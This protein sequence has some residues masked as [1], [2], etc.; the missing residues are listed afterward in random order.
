[1]SE[2]LTP[3]DEYFE[4]IGN[5]IGNPNIFKSNH[6]RY[7]AISVMIGLVHLRGRYS[8]Q[9]SCNWQSY[10]PHPLL[11]RIQIAVTLNSLIAEDN[12]LPSKIFC[13]DSE[14]TLVENLSESGQRQ[15]GAPSILINTARNDEVVGGIKKIGDNTLYVSGST[16]SY[17]LNEYNLRK[18]FI[19]E[20]PRLEE[21]ELPSRLSIREMMSHINDGEW[22]EYS[23]IDKRTK[24]AP[25][26]GRA[27]LFMIP[28]GIRVQLVDVVA[29]TEGGI[30]RRLEAI[31][32]EIID[33]KDQY[34]L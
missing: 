28:T 24:L 30:K 21:L 19:Y 26:F 29:E 17:S 10:Q 13:N 4:N 23:S 7:N 5:I 27:S 6:G 8:E 2:R 33:H 9:P 25:I 31:N 12:P 1:M 15:C 16:D 3:P 22:R 20:I 11:E 18:G 32:Q 34:I 14:T